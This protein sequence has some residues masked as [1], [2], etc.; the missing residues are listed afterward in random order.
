MFW[1][2]GV[3]PF[4]RFDDSTLLVFGVLKCGSAG[5]TR[6]A[7]CVMRYALCVMRYALCVMRDALCVMR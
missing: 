6:D 5:V 2:F 4:C 3:L 7:L 1:R